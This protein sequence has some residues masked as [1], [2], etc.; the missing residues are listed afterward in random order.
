[1][2]AGIDKYGG[3]L[4]GK[5]EPIES[6]SAIKIASSNSGLSLDEVIETAAA[7]E[8]VVVNVPY[9]YLKDENDTNS[10]VSGVS[11]FLLTAQLNPEAGGLMWV[12]QSSLQNVYKNVVAMSQMTSM[13]RDKD[14]NNWYEHGIKQAIATFK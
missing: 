11:K 7:E 6:S 14:R 3:T 12:E 13:L 8:T 10:T 5:G 2:Y 9:S 4:V 1:M